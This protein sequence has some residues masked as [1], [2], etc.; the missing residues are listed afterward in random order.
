MLQHVD[1]VVLGSGSD[2]MMRRVV[3]RSLA[4]SLC[5]SIRGTPYAEL[6]IGVPKDTAALERRVSQTPETG[7]LFFQGGLHGLSGVRSRRGREFQR[8][9][10]R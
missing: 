3:R 9:G 6:S 8:L 10:V 7:T 5:T 4:R 2:A 1:R